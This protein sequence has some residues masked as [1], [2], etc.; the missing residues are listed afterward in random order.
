MLSY[1]IPC[2]ESGGATAELIITHP[3]TNVSRPQPLDPQPSANPTANRDRIS[4]IRPRIN[5]AHRDLGENG[6]GVSVIYYYLTEAS[7]RLISLLTPIF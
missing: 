1:S 4:S 7:S 3:L 5:H 6:R 2:L